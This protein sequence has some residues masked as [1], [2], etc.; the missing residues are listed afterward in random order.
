[1]SFSKLSPAKKALQDGARAPEEAAASL[2]VAPISKK[3]GDPQAKGRLLNGGLYA[4]ADRQLK[5]S[6]LAMKRNNWD[7]FVQAAEH[8]TGPLIDLLLQHCSGR[9]K[10]CDTEETAKKMA[11]GRKDAKG[12]PLKGDKYLVSI[13]VQLAVSLL[14]VLFSC[15]YCL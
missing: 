1:M 7:A 6:L 4:D 9:Y 13:A 10:I 11:K 5:E 8:G 12:Y 3:K 15:L 14:L 2:S